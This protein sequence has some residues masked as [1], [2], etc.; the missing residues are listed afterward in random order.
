MSKPHTPSLL[1]IVHQTAIAPHLFTFA[2]QQQPDAT[3]ENLGMV[4][5]EPNDPTQ[6]RP[7]KLLPHSTSKNLA[8]LKLLNNRTMIAYFVGGLEK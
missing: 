6:R 3:W 1:R 4:N 8:F 7:T 2:Q 5:V